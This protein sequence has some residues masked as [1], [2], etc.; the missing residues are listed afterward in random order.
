MT[1]SKTSISITRSENP[2]SDAELAAILADPGFGLHFTD[3][4]F[5]AEWTPEKGW[6]DARITPYGPLT[7]DPAT[8]VL[9]YAQE[10]FE[11]LKAYRRD[12]GSVWT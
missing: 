12:D 4:M 7:L 6:H 10:V 11:G 5:T 9:H 2:R 8:A 1:T 3:H